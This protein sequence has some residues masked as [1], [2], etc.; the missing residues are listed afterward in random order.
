MAEES[1]MIGKEVL[2]DQ[3]ADTTRLTARQ[4]L[5]K[6]GTGPA[7]HHVVLDLAALHG[8][9]TIVDVGCGNGTYLAELHRRGHNGLV[10]GLDLSEG[11]ARNSSVHAATAVADAQ[12]LPLPDGSVDI[13]LSLHMLYHVPNLT[14]AVAE[15]RRVLR[16]GGTVLVAT[17]GSGHTVEAKRILATAARA[18]TGMDVDLDW[19]TRRF[20]P[21]LANRL[22]GTAFDEVDLHEL[23]D[24]F[25]V[26]DPAVITD[27][28]ASWP[29][30]SIGLNAGPVWNQVLAAT[31]EL[32]AAHFATHSAFVITSRAAVLR[33]R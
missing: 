3:Y 7:L 9:E 17:N 29:P 8:T 22:L 5:W 2:H 27:Y 23:G 21:V 30:E 4:S 12:A 32:V 25:P 26:P 14:Q 10:V 15:L 28:V 1:T 13:V 19:D 33:C 24:T 11:M 6:H 31:R 20:D 18:V 16:P